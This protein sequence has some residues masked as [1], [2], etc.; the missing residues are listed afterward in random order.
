MEN[1]ETNAGLLTQVFTFSHSAD[2]LV[3]TRSTSCE[4][5]RRLCSSLTTV[6]KE[7]GKSQWGL[8]SGTNPDA[9]LGRCRVAVLSPL[10]I[11][12]LPSSVPSS[13]PVIGITAF[14]LRG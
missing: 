9:S 11:L 2:T 3:L 8:K 13:A 6:C 10:P 5:T 12:P 1:A 14:T 4:S 7:R